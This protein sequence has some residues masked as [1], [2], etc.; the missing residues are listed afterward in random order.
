MKILKLIL[1]TAF[2]AIGLNALAQEPGEIQGLIYDLETN[3]PLFSATAKVTYAG[4]TK[5]EAA[6]FDG[7]FSIKPLTAGIYVLEVEFV[8]YQT[9]KQEIVVKSGQ[10]SFRD[11]IFLSAGEIIGEIEVIAWKNPLI[12][13]YEVSKPTMDGEQMKGMAILRNPATLLSTLSDGAI[14]SVGSGGE[15]DEV[16]FR[17]SRTGSIV[18]YLDGM[19]IYGTVPTFP[20][21]AISS[22]SVYTGG[23]PAKYGD[24]SGGVIEI[25]TKS[26]FDLYNQRMAEL[27]E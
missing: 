2:V 9:I 3:K 8:G 13:P 27:N 7:R 22:Y 23:L 14:S 20:A 6:D 11:T 18:T 17:G 19:K 26:Y 15:D 4:N 5:G 10:I 24:T 16:Y 21:V 1:A 25:E 12:N